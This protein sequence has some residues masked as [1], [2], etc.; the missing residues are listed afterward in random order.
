ML[1]KNEKPNRMEK[2][3]KV[4]K[5]FSWKLLLGFI[6]FEIVFTGITAP[7]LL[8]YGPFEEAKKTYVGAAMS[9]MSNKWLATMFLSDEKINEIIGTNQPAEDLEKQDNSLVEI[10]KAKDDT[11]VQYTLDNNPKFVG[12]VL[13]IS[14][15]TRVKVGVS[16]KLGTEGETV[17]EI[18]D[19]Y[20]AVAAI[21]GGAFTDEANTQKWTS[22]GGIPVGLLICDGEVKHNDVGNNK[23]G[24]AAITKEGRLLAGEYTL[25][26]LQK[27]G[28]RDAMSFSP[29]LVR[30]SKAVPISVDQ[31]TAPRTMIGQKSNGSIVLVVLDSKLPGDRIAASLKEAQEV[32]LTL[33]CVTATN[34]DG[35][36][37]TTMY[38][39]GEVINNPSY[40][41][42]E[43][44]IAS[45]FIVK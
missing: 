7:F 26:E 19:H 42:G 37:S 28:V 20:D 12:H 3:K 22:N 2:N 40:A 45:G 23:V 33:G 15:P 30:N 9:T 35:G 39:N 4:K 34:L 14:D 41:L 13:V 36:K 31:G 44:P 29:V 6:V 43:R 16:S 27:E 25:A 18:A 38:Y 5:K 1:K 24:V 11:I 32:M 8:L 21:N 10:P 17:S